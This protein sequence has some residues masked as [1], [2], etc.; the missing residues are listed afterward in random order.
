MRIHI[1][2]FLIIP[3][4]NSFSQD[5]SAAYTFL[6][7]AKFRT[8]MQTIAEGWNDGNAQKS[9]DC[10]DNDAVYIEPPNVQF[11][12]GKIQLFEFFGGEK[13]FDI[14]M[15]MKWHNLAFD[16]E[17]QVGFGEYTFQMYNKYHGIVVVNF[18]LSL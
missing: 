14:P 4:T 6:T 9:A 10:F 3:F 8:L 13:G 18:L 5:K 7:T 2:I 17:R 12:K 15:K 1:L 11:Y 16:E